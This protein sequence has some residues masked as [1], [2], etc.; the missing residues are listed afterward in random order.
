LNIA[1]HPKTLQHWRD[2]QFRGEEAFGYIARRI[3][4]RLVAQK[5]SYSSKVRAGGRLS[6][7]L[8]L[9]NAGF[10]SP[11]LP[12]V[13]SIALIQGSRI[14]RLALN[15]VDARRWSP[16]SGNIMVRGEMSVPKT[17]IDNGTSELAL[18]L[19]DP[20]PRLRNDGRYAIRLANDDVPFLAEE[21]WNILADDIVIHR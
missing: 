12:R 2:S 11:L 18:Q 3:G 15:A 1:Y 4:Y 9:T 8:T 7:Q 5:L 20:S 17:F 10:A 19:A 6:F 14:E 13:V 16:W 21:G